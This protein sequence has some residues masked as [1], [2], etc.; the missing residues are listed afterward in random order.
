MWYS[1]GI[2]LYI[3]FMHFV[4]L[5]T[6]VRCVLCSA[7][8]GCQGCRAR[9][10]WQLAQEEVLT[11]VLQL[12]RHLSS[13]R[14]RLACG[15]RATGGSLWLDLHCTSDPCKNSAMERAALDWSHAHT[16]G[17]K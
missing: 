9:L 3:S 10:F 8:G 4:I 14:H 16:C 1:G 7:C 5:F 6:V 2:L 11:E 17:K 12:L 13:T 15:N